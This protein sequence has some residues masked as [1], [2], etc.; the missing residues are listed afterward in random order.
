VASA[1]SGIAM[2]AEILDRF[3]AEGAVLRLSADVVA[4]VALQ[5]QQ[6]QFHATLSSKVAEA[7]PVVGRSSMKFGHALSE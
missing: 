4:G 7:I 5:D 3:T 2:L 6:R 1:D